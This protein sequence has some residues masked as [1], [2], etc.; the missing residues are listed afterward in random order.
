ML[1][2][3]YPTIY[4]RLCPNNKLDGLALLVK[5]RL[6]LGQPPPKNGR[7]GGTDGQDQVSY[8]VVGWVLVDDLETLVAA[9]IAASVQPPPPTLVAAHAAATPGASA[10]LTMTDIE[11]AT[12]FDDT[13]LGGLRC[14]GAIH[15]GAGLG[16]PVWRASCASW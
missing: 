3:I 12:N 9:D 2:K 11:S 10:S 6:C 4:N 1:K 5:E 7:A 15:P 13:D 8:P 14:R 16:R